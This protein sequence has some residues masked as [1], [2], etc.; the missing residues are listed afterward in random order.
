[1]I[2]LHTLK[3]KSVL[4]LQNVDWMMIYLG[5]VS[6]VLEQ[7]YMCEQMIGYLKNIGGK[8]YKWT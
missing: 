5:G 6:D 3:A 1:M 4:A 7:Q 2:D 8:N